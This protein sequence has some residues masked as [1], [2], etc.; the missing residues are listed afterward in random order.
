MNKAERESFPIPNAL[1]ENGNTENELRGERLGM[2][3][4]LVKIRGKPA[5]LA[6]DPR[7]SGLGNRRKMVSW[8]QLPSF[9]ATLM[10]DS[11][12]WSQ[13]AL[14]DVFHESIGAPMDTWKTPVFCTYLIPWDR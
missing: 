6:R 12:L 1:I 10:Q 2:V 7:H 11:I 13:F 8:L 9:K 14:T 4:H 5:N 3:R